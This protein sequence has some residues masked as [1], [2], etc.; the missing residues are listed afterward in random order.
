VNLSAYA[1]HA[2]QLQFYFNTVDGLYNAFEGWFVNNLAV[3]DPAMGT[4]FA[5]DG[6]KDAS[7][8][9]STG[10]PGTAPGWHQ[11][12]RRTADFGSR[13]WWYGD[14]ATGT[15]QYLPVDGCSGRLNNGTL[16]SPIIPL[17]GTSTLSFDTLWQIE[18]I[19]PS[20]YDLMQVRVVDRGF[21]DFA[22]VAKAPKADPYY[23]NTFDPKGPNNLITAFSSSIASANLY[24]DGVLGQSV[25]P[26][27]L[28]S[29][30]PPTNADGTP[31]YTSHVLSVRATTKTGALVVSA[32]ITL[33]ALVSEQADAVAILPDEA[34]GLN[35]FSTDPYL[36]GCLNIP[37]SCAGQPPFSTPS[38][39]FRSINSLLVE[40]KSN[41]TAFIEPARS[42]RSVKAG[43]SFYCDTPPSTAVSRANTLT[44]PIND[45]GF[46]SFVSTYET[47]V[48]V[49]TP[50]PFRVPTPPGTTGPTNQSPFV[51]WIFDSTYVGIQ[52]NGT[53]K[54]AWGDTTSQPTK[55]NSLFPY[56]YLFVNGVLTTPVPH[57]KPD[58]V[59]WTR[60]ADASPVKIVDAISN[61]LPWPMGYLWR[62]A[63]EKTL[64]AV[65]LDVA[66]TVVLF[67][68]ERAE[69]ARQRYTT[70]NPN[71]EAYL[72]QNFPGVPPWFVIE[73]SLKDNV[74][75]HY[76]WH[77]FAQGVSKTAF[78]R[79]PNCVIPGCPGLENM[80]VVGVFSPVNVDVYNAAGKHSGPLA[81]GSIEQGIDSVTYLTTGD[82][83]LL[84]IP[85]DPAYRVVLTGTDAGV[86]TLN[87]TDFKGKS[88]LEFQQYAS[89][90]VTPK[91]RGTLTMGSIGTPVSWDLLGTGV[92][93]ALTA[94]TT[95]TNPAD[96]GTDLT[97]PTTTASV[98]GTAGQPGYY[99]S[100]VDIRLVGTDDLSGVAKTEYSL[101]NGTTWTPYT[102]PV[103]LSADGSYQM[104]YRSADWAGNQEVAKPLSFV[105]DT[106]PPT[107]TAT[108]GPAPLPPGYPSV[109]LQINSLVIDPGGALPPT[110]CWGTQGVN[111]ALNA[112][113]NPGGSGVSEI[114]YTLTGAQT[115]SGSLGPAGGTV[116]I[117][118]TGTTT[119]TYYAVDKAGNQESPRV[120]KVF[121]DPSIWL[122]CVPAPTF[123]STIPPQGTVTVS[124]TF[125]INGWTYPFNKT[126]TFS[127]D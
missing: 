4:L 112:V 7:G 78:V 48:N 1:N 92:P 32:P 111:V 45:A 94:S 29:W 124:G 109:T 54:A 118:A 9:T 103:H 110:T 17:G 70:M 93:V 99:R 61:F 51:P 65:P 101:D 126:F 69:C 40:G 43:D 14:E 18:S 105:I 38:G 20:S 59:G 64:Q 102:A 66:A 122:A 73:Q 34:V 56:H 11:T 108:P 25:W 3:T 83:K 63:L 95:T 106:V 115:G 55:G 62:K 84:I 81:D 119:L 98:T 12:S 85:N 49:T 68:A 37:G 79:D 46:T 19:N 50:D 77:E 44:G 26:G 114:R 107:S 125:T 31:L 75:P 82:I 121:L 21:A 90:D 33:Y 87:A 35:P 72:Q 30:A 36:A 2:V 24:V 117:T 120:I 58:L 96:D 113:D 104:L 28:Y 42:S 80:K 47:R 116:P 8:W 89:V 88:K 23:T 86:M 76:N 91:S 27:G 39:S 53:V 127:R 123:P 5:F 6:T 97:P 10:V 71:L 74:R 41:G 60:T 67:S 52:P 100:A 22:T 13:S 15:F 57:P 16:T